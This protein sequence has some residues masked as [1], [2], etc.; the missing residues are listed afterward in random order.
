M[1]CW[2]RR[3]CHGETNSIESLSEEWNSL[4][5]QCIGSIITGDMNIHHRHWLRF[6]SHVPPE[7]TAL[8]NWCM[9]RGFREC[10]RAPT[11]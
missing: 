2:Y 5:G 9:E 8:K 10:I 3:P 4:A 6:S 11:R 7:G 1:C